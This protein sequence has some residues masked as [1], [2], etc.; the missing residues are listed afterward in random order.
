MGTF[1][2]MDNHSEDDNGAD[3]ADNT[4]SSLLLLPRQFLQS[5]QFL[6]SRHTSRPID[7]HSEED[8]NNA[9]NADNTSSSLLLLP[10]QFLHSLQFL[11]SRH[12]SRPIDDHHP[13]DDS[14]HHA[15]NADNIYY[16]SIGDVRK[17]RTML[18]QLANYNGLG[19]PIELVDMI[20]DE[21]EY[22]PSILTEMPRPISVVQDG[23]RQCLL[24]PPLCHHLVC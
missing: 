17:T 21:A 22:W 23:D 5:L 13:D 24:T 6:S 8:N 11:S 3:N 4:S 19:L 15:D 16:P 14:G 18:H 9:D 2:P 10:R 20:I 12:T 1:T 7:D